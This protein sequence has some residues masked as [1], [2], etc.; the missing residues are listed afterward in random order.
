LPRRGRS[1]TSRPRAARWP[2]ISASTG[3]LE[4]AKL[5]A[6]AE[7]YQQQQNADAIVAERAAKA[8]GIQ[9]RNEALRGSGGR[10]LVKL[11]LAEALDGTPIVL[12]P[13][14]A[15]GVGLN[16]LDLNRLL[17]SALLSRETGSGASGP[18]SGGSGAEEKKSE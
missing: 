5:A 13:G 18:E 8:K 15:S 14:G 17:E 4:Q 2:P 12:I 3:A 10:A 7:Y 6:D 9:K 16:K 11:R 1:A